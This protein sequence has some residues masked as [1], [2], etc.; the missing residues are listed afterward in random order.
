[1]QDRR[2][3]KRRF[4]MYYSR[5]YD[6]STETLVG[7]LGDITPLGLMI[8]S[9]ASLPVDK[10]FTL[11]IEL[12]AEVSDRPDFTVNARSLWCQPDV[13]PGIYNT[14]FELINPSVESL[15]IIQHI[16]DNFGF[17]DNG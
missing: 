15:E 9:D 4:L 1:M 13:A 5:I 6:T 17:R 10:L 14:G 12:S 8:I 16:V 11:K 3:T 7:Q 2:R